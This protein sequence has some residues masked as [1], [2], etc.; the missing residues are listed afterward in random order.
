MNK[1]INVEAYDYYLE[2]E[3]SNG[4]K[5]KYDMSDIVFSE[6]KMEKELQDV[7]FFKKVFIEMGALAWPNGYE[8]HAD[9]IIRDG[10]IISVKAS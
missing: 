6:K 1:I 4:K 10:E 2:C 3:C 7:D 5:Y 8:I 9:T